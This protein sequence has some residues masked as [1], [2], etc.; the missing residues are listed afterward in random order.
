MSYQ[1]RVR[2][3]TEKEKLEEYYKRDMNKELLEQAKAQLNSV[4]NH[5]RSL[6]VKSIE[7]DLKWLYKLNGLNKP[8]IIIAKSY[9]HFKILK[10][11]IKTSDDRYND[12][13]IDHELGLLF[14]NDYFVYVKYLELMKQVI[15]YR[16]ERYVNFLSKGI[17]ILNVFSKTALVCPMPLKIMRDDQNRFHSLQKPAIKW[18]NKQGKHFIHGVSFPKQLWNKVIKRELTVKE[19][20]QIDNIERRYVSLQLYDLEQIIKETQA[21]VI[22][23]S[24]RGNTLYEITI[25]DQV[26]KALKYQ[27]PSTQRIYLSYVP[28]EINDADQAMAWKF[29]I[30]IEEYKTLR[31]EG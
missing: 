5:S 9:R 15:P 20:L 19:V 3:R 26:I 28:L 4:V 30:S 10:E 11:Q 18:H 16:I 23:K 6:T 8:R 17:L 29:K 12:H 27:C 22:H 13:E 24:D 1:A 31:I 21:K 7:D 2:S 25:D 14:E